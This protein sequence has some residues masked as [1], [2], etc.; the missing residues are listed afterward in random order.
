VIPDTPQPGHELAAP[1]VEAMLVVIGV[2][3]P[4][5]PAQA[6]MGGCLGG[7]SVVSEGTFRPVKWASRGALLASDEELAVLDFSGLSGHE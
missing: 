1:I 6:P 5:P 7:R 3:F 4:A 2:G